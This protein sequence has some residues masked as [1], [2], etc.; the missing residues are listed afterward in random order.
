MTAVLWILADIAVVLVL[1]AV[2]AIWRAISYL[3]WRKDELVDIEIQRRVAEAQMHR[4]ATSAVQDIMNAT[5]R[6][7]LPD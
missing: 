7:G 2:G 5:R 3:D 1:S 4:A 6:S